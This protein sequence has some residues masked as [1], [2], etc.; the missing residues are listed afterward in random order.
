MRA[1]V[2]SLK[3]LAVF[4][5]V[6]PPLGPDAEDALGQEDR[7]SYTTGA[8]DADEVEKSYDVSRDQDRCDARDHRGNS[9]GQYCG[10][11]AGR[12]PGASGA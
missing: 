4:G 7:P 2:Q 8:S 1:I 11:N 6:A 5:L 10:P 9:R 12:D 3:S